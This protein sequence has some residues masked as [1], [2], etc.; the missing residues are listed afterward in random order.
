MGELLSPTT[1]VHLM[2]AKDASMIK[3]T[4]QIETG[5]DRSPLPEIHSNEERIDRFLQ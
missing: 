3:I 2:A 5:I 1:E 4:T